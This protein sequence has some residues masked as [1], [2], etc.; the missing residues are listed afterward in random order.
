M[1]SNQMEC[2][3]KKWR[4]KSEKK[5]DFLKQYLYSQLPWKKVR[6][7]PLF[8][9]FAF[10]TLCHFFFFELWCNYLNRIA[11]RNEYIMIFSLFRCVTHFSYIFNFNI[12]QMLLYIFSIL[13]VI[14]FR[15]LNILCILL[16][17]KK[18]SFKK[19]FH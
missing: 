2:K 10:N 3:Q 12:F 15:R 18:Q 6:F 5:M 7:K 17:I 19:Q 14:F 4:K 11:I 16:S 13:W 1:N 8:L 9:R